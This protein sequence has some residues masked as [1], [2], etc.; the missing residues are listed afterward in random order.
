MPAKA[1]ERTH[2]HY[3]TNWLKVIDYHLTKHH[4]SLPY[5]FIEQENERHNCNQ[6]RPAKLSLARAVS[7]LTRPCKARPGQGQSQSQSQSQQS[8][9]KQHN[10][11]LWKKDCFVSL[12]QSLLKVQAIELYNICLF[13]LG[14]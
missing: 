8:Q 10:I 12:M 6:P 13:D 2:E 1:F 9:F 7:S 4:L 11:N 14:N 5:C 3:Y